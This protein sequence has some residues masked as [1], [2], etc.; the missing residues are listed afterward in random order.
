MF[1]STTLGILVTLL[2]LVGF[3]ATPAFAGGCDATVTAPASIQAAIDAN[4]GGVVCLTD[5]GGEFAQQVVFGP[6][7][8]GIT[9]TAEPGAT[10]A[11]NGA[12]LVP[13]FANRLITTKCAASRTPI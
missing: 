13:S 2:T 1:R 12:T 8:S 7:D 6:E 11:L 9:L 4:P 10:P 5:S 3:S